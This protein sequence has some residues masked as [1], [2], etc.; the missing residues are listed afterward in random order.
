MEDDSCDADAGVVTSPASEAAV[1]RKEA[2]ARRYAAF[3]QSTLHHNN[4]Y[5]IQ[6]LKYEQVTKNCNLASSSA[7]KYFM[8]EVLN[9]AVDVGNIYFTDIFLGGRFIKYGT[10]VLRWS[11]YEEKKI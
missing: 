6:V 7:Q 2:V 3:F 5:F 4:G 11:S 10:R 1:L 9:L 8:C